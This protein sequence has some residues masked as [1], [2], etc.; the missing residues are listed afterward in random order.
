MANGVLGTLR[1]VRSCADPKFA[2]DEGP[3]ADFGFDGHENQKVA[4]GVVFRFRGIAGECW[5]LAIFA[6]RDTA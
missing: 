4:R 1:V 2:Y 6:N 5:V 3:I